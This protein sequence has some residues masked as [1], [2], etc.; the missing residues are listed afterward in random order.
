MDQLFEKNLITTKDA[1]ELSGYSSDYLARLARSGKIIGRRIGHS[2]FVER[3]SL[4]HFLSQQENRKVNYARAL[5]REREAEYREHH[6]LLH[7]AAKILSKPLPLPSL[8]IEERAL[9]SHVFALS[10]AFLVVA[11]GAFLAQ[12]APLTSFASTTLAVAREAASGFG[13]TFGNIPLHIA[14]KIDFVS[15]EVLAYPARV[16]AQS[17]RVSKKIAPTI[18]AELDFSALQMATGENRFAIVPQNLEVRQPQQLWMSD[19]RIQDLQALAI[20]SYAFITTPSLAADMFARAYVAV[21]NEAYAAIAKT[22]SDYRSLIVRSGTVA[23]SLAA[24]S[25]DTFALAPHLIAQMNLALG[26][27]VINAT[28]TAI[29]AEVTTAFGLSET[30]P[31]SGRAVIALVVNTGGLLAGSVAQTPELA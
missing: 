19:F 8:H 4:V 26:N 31:A 30:L 11:S 5:A 27:A 24:T 14:A 29:R 22:F 2:W 15:K 18:L 25:R 17:E 12:A 20:S 28:H 10:V 7:N 3:E 16:T 23:L 21:G 1:G 6:S 9:R 13:A